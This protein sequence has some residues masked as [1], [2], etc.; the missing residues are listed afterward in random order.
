MKKLFTLMLL[1][2]AAVMTTATF[3][4]CGDDDDDNTPSVAGS[5]TGKDELDFSVMGQSYKQS[6]TAEVNYIVTQNN[7]GSISVVIPEETFDYS[8][9][10]MGNMS[11][12]SIVQGTYSVT[13]IPYDKAKNAYYLD[14]SNKASADVFVYGAKKNYTITEGKITVSFSGNKV[15]V[16]NVHK[17]GNMPMGMTGTFVGT[18]K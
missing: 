5:Y 18:R 1:F 15:T 17:F 16:V 2:M 10:K 9:V 7:D 4:S 12:G 11:M 8:A 3:T 6:N 14:Y 13:N